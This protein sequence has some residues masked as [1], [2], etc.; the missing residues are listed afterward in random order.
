MGRIRSS[1]GPLSSVLDRPLS[2][3]LIQWILQDPSFCH[4]DPIVFMAGLGSCPLTGIL[5]WPQR[6][7]DG[8]LEL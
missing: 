3:R 6:R 2:E 7:N 4:A 1:S 5:R 8:L